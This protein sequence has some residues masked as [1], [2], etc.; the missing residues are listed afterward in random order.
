MAELANRFPTT[1]GIYPSTIAKIEGGNRG[2]RVDELATLAD[3]FG[4][5][6]DA[7]MGRASSGT[8]LVWAMNRLSSD[9]QKSAGEVSAI[10]DRLNSEVDD[11]LEYATDDTRP[12][13]LL[14]SGFKALAALQT[15]VN[16]LTELAGEFPRV[17]G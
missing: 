7:L 17:G 5:S 13:D 16:T 6:V 9:A 3:V 11:V 10:M 1:L 4:I 12:S 15:A 8:D 2:V 14:D